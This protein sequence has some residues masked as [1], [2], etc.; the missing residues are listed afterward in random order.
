MCDRTRSIPFSGRAEVEGCI[1]T[2]RNYST[3]N[4]LN[5]MSYWMTNG[6]SSSLNW[7]CYCW[8]RNSSWTGD[9]TT[10]NR[11]TVNRTMANWTTGN[12]TTVNRTMV[13]QTTVNQ[14]TANQTTAN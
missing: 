2:T 14:T 5:S 6:C 1:P 12:Q 13:N 10:R 3:M 11:A 9:W 7:S 8:T 4:C